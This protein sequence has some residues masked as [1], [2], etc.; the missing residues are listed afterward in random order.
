MVQVMRMRQH[1]T[2]SIPMDTYRVHLVVDHYS[3]VSKKRL[4][5]TTLSLEIT[6]NSKEMH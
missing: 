2:T 5:S 1:F 6:T 3:Q 4:I